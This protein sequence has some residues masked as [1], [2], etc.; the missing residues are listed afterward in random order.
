LKIT[1]FLHGLLALG[2]EQLDDFL[3]DADG[4]VEGRRE[5]TRGERRRRRSNS[6]VLVHFEDE[7]AGIVEESD[8]DDYSLSS[9]PSQSGE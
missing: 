2:D 7:L 9:S 4:A 6:L 3:L 8:Y 1:P 5:R